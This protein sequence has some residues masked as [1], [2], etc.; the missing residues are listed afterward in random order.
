MTFAIFSPYIFHSI[1]VIC[2]N[3]DKCPIHAQAQP[4][5][6]LAGNSCCKVF[7]QH[8]DGSEVGLTKIVK[9]ICMLEDHHQAVYLL[10]IML[11]QNMIYCNINFFFKFVT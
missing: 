2:Y 1:G 6:R 9:K 3:T 4:S 5:I 10:R 11:L 8:M 7:L